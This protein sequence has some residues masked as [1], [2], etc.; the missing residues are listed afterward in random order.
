MFTMK[1]SILLKT[2]YLLFLVNSLILGTAFLYESNYYYIKLNP[3]L[4][5]F[6]LLIIL[7][8][9]ILLLIKKQNKNVVNKEYKIFV[10]ILISLLLYFIFNDLVV[11]HF[12]FS[13]IKNYSIFIFVLF[14]NYFL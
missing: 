4:Y 8:S 1:L 2:L 12:E 11:N 9:C 6:I 5:L 7:S 14:G 3:Y 10:I 13:N